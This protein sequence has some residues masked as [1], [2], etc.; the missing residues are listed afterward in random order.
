VVSPGAWERMSKAPLPKQ[1][2][3]VEGVDFPTVALAEARWERDRL[4]L[5]LHPQ[6]EAVLGRPPRFRVTG[7]DD[8]AQWRVEGDAQLAPRAGELVVKTSVRD[9]RLTLRPAE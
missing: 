9:H 7:L 6:S 2:G 4:H 1:R 8:P 3:L 5:R